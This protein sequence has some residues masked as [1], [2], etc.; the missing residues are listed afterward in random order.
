MRKRSDNDLSEFIDDKTANQERPRSKKKKIVKQKSDAQLLAHIVDPRSNADAPKF[1]KKTRLLHSDLGPND[2]LRPT[3]DLVIHVDFGQSE[4]QKQLTDKTAEEWY[5][6]RNVR[7]RD[8][9][10]RRNHRQ[11]NAEIKRVLGL[12]TKHAKL[13]NDLKIINELIRRDFGKGYDCLDVNIEDRP[14]KNKKIEENN[15]D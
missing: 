4:E 6:V 14:Y 15:N 10:V 9:D 3:T 11:R 7:K 8:A 12:K 1:K 13:S 5:R 2:V